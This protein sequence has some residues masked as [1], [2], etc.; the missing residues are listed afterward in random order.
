[1]AIERPALAL[2]AVLACFLA[3]GCTEPGPEQS[4]TSPADL[5]SAL[6]ATPGLA[7]NSS[8]ASPPGRGAPTLSGRTPSSTTT[9]E[10]EPTD[11]RYDRPDNH[12]LDPEAL[13]AFH[14]ALADS[15]I[16]ASVI[17]KDGYIVDEYYGPGYD[18]TSLFELN[19]CTKSF[20]GALIGVA[21]E[22]GLI[23]SISDPIAK[24]FPPVARAEG[25]YWQRITVEHLL[26]HSSGLDWEGSGT[27][28][29]EW[30]GSDNWTDFILNRT[31]GGEPGL[32][33]NYSTMGVHLLTAAFEE[34]SGRALDD[35]GREHIFEPLGMRSAHWGK[36]PDGVTDGGNGLTMNVHDA[37]KFGQLFLNGGSWDGRQLIPAAWIAK[38]T[39]VQAPD[40]R[41]P[42]QYGYQWWI[43]EFAGYNTYLAQGHGGQVIFVVPELGL[44][45][46]F[47]SSY[48]G[49]SSAPFPY[50]E[51]YVLAALV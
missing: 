29:Q 43:R 28:W 18:E 7:P 50:F 12:G 23:D 26:T 35:Y 33:F 6:P 49:E 17:V 32:R 20:T 8:T 13:Q 44:V 1:M 48:G 4:P 31:I 21:L 19:S 39:S 25:E 41:R 37:A 51:D 15:Q 36:G 14:S 46:V 3:F 34:A 9:A 22:E 11:W 38:S 40:T 42:S 45:T 2:P 27:S 47:T 5:D 30:R 10:P 16:H 24:Y